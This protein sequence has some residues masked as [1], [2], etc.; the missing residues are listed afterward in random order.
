MFGETL[1]LNTQQRII[2]DMPTT[3]ADFFEYLQSCDEL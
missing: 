1:M 2:L 3:L